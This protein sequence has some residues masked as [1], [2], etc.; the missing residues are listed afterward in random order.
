MKTRKLTFIRENDGTWYVQLKWWPKILRPM[1]QMVAGADVLLEKYYIDVVNDMKINLQAKDICLR[2]KFY[3]TLAISESPFDNYDD[4]ITLDSYLNAELKLTSWHSG[5]CYELQKTDIVLFA[6]NHPPLNESLF[7]DNS[8]SATFTAARVPRSWRRWR[9]AR[10]PS[11]TSTG[12]AVSRWRR[13]CA[14]MWCRSLS[15]RRRLRNWTAA[16]ADGR[17]TATR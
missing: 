10:T 4:C 15:C 2:S 1:L 8:I 17:R 14:T 9:P 5:R 11:L 7:F 16:C 12:R 13:R 6:N 3:V